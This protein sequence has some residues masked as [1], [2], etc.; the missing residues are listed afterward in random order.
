MEKTQDSMTA[1]KL[2]GALDHEKK[3]AVRD[4]KTALLGR[5]NRVHSSDIKV[6][7]FECLEDVKQI[8][9]GVMIFL[10]NGTLDDTVKAKGNKI[11]TAITSLLN[12]QLSP[13]EP[14]IDSSQNRY[15]FKDGSQARYE[16]YTLVENTY[17][18][19][20]LFDRMTKLMNLSSDGFAFLGI[21]DKKLW[22][23]DDGVE[24]ID[25]TEDRF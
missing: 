15:V 1:K 11:V 18:D 24:D 23:K 8:K 9:S 12:T 14:T 6:E 5:L 19:T 25:V 3:K 21:Q 7:Y 10:N 17:R 13:P 20:V 22:V 4:L 16:D 2:L